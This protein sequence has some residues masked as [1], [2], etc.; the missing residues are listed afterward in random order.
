M[1]NISQNLPQKGRKI[2][3]AREGIYRLYFKE[4]AQFTPNGFRSGTLALPKAVARELRNQVTSNG[5]RLDPAY[6]IAE[7]AEYNE[8]GEECLVVMRHDP[9]P[10]EPQKVFIPI[11]SLSNWVGDLRG[12]A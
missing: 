10:D 5:I 6:F 12:S 8:D 9:D 1:E 4:I 2:I 11:S 7:D 3:D